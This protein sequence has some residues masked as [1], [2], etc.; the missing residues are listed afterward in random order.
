MAPFLDLLAAFALR[1]GMRQRPSSRLLIVDR[2]A[3][4]LLFRFAFGSGALIG[5]SFWATPGGGLDPGESYEDAARRELAEETG[6]KVEDPGP[7]VGQRTATF[8]TPDGETVIADERYFLIQVDALDV[9]SDRWT[10]LEREVMAEHRWWS[11]TDLGAT[12]D[13]VWPENLHDLLIEAGVWPSA[14]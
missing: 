9:S 14:V 12:T 6:L 11:P 5:Q 3:R 8:R 4:V 1:S 10:Q 13:Q 7:Q 2:D